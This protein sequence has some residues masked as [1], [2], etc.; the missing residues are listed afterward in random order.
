MF[1][2]FRGFLFASITYYSSLVYTD[3]ARITNSLPDDDDINM[4]ASLCIVYIV[5]KFQHTSL[6]SEFHTDLL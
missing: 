3:M 5:A 4:I 6:H 1:K 2:L